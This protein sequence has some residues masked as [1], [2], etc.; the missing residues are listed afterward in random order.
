MAAAGNLARAG[1]E[2]IRWDRNAPGSNW[3]HEIDP[4]GP[5]S[6][7]C[8]IGGRRNRNPC[9]PAALMAGSRPPRRPGS[10]SGRGFCCRSSV[11]E[12][13]LGKG[14]VVSSILPGSTSRNVDESATFSDFSRERS[15]TGKSSEVRNDPA[16]SANSDTLGR[17]PLRGAGLA[18]L[19]VPSAPSPPLHRRSIRLRVSVREVRPAWTLN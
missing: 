9:A 6:R 12:H 14:E 3:F 18:L 4:S 11:V 19:A 2:F 15:A 13:P 1:R 8:G 5:I 10:F 17:L 7:R 16:T